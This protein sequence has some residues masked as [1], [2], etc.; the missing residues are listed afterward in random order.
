MCVK[1]NG[2]GGGAFGG[3]QKE[4]PAFGPWCRLVPSCGAF[5]K[6]ALIPKRAPFARCRCSATRLRASRAPAARSRVREAEMC[7][8]TSRA[9][10]ARARTCLDA[11]LV[12]VLF[13][14]RWLKH[15]QTRGWPNML[16]R[17]FP[18]PAPT[19]GTR[20]AMVYYPCSKVRVVVKTAQS[21]SDFAIRNRVWPRSG[22]SGGD[23][24]L[25]A[26]SQTCYS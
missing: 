7:G 12:V 22:S 15:P 19:T 13:E 2:G 3:C 10:T 4:M 17:G 9:A 16:L 20:A 21:D 1:L 8:T 6:G 23:M 25:D 5:L 11:C 18:L 24:V 26:A 14:Q